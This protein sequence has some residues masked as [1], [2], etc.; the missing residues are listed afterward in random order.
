[1]AP[2]PIV[3]A[4]DCFGASVLKKI[5][6][7]NAVQTVLALLLAGY[8]NLVKW[9]TRWSRENLHFVQPLMDE[10]DGVIGA[11]WHGRV[12][13]TIAGWPRGVQPAKILISHSRDG[14]FIAKATRYVKIG[15]IR[16]STRKKTKRQDKGGSSAFREMVKHIEAGGCMAMTPDGPRGPRMHCS[17]GVVRLAKMTGAPIMIYAWSTRWRIVINSWD[18][19]ILPLPFGRGTIVWGDPV[20]VDADA[21]DADLKAARTLIE[22]RLTAATQAADAACGVKVIEPAPAKAVT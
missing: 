9:T 8:M 16:G 5:L 4:P 21:T 20:Y 13:M 15:T 7:S 1:M 6:R 10:G 3:R 22:Q 12:L 2:F 17:E 14:A 11:V 19:F 18:K